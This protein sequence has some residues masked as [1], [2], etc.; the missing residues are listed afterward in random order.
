[1][2][3]LVKRSSESRL[4]DIDCSSLLGSTETIGSVASIAAEPTTVPALAFGSPSVNTNPVTYV[5]EDTGLSRVVAAGK[6]I[7]VQISGGAIPAA[8]QSQLY[9]IRPKFATNLDPVVEATV[10]LLVNDTP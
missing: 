6:V 10:Q 2:Q 7:Q 8:L 3:I 5:D 9:V 4:F 1:M